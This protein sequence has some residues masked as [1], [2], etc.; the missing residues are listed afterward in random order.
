MK[1]RL[2]SK[3]M[4]EEYVITCKKKKNQEVMV[5]YGVRPYEKKY[6]CPSAAIFNS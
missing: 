5:S 3:I 6:T 1:F 2:E 4:S